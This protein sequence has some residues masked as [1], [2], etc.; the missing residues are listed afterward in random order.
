MDNQ[1]ENQQSL[2]LQRLRQRYRSGVTPEAVMTQVYEQIAAY[3]DP[4]I[5]IYLAPLAD[6]LARAR[7]L[8]QQDLDSLP[9]YGVP[10]AIKDNID[11]AESSTTA[12]C[13]AFAYRP[14]QSAR[15]VQQLCAAGAIPIGKTNLDQFATGLVGTRSPYGICR[16]PFDPRFIPGGSSAGSGVAV[17]AGLVSFALGTDTAGS[18]R[19]PAAFTNIVGLKP[20]K[21]YLSTR[22]LVPAVRS[23]DCISIFAL[24]CADAET[25]LQAAAGFDSADAWSRPAAPLNLPDWAKLRVGVPAVESLKF[26]G[27]AE[28]ERNYRAGLERLQALGGQLVE[29][30][31]S[32]FAETAPL[33][34]Q[35]AWVAER[36]AALGDFLSQNLE[37]MEPTVRQIIAGGSA[38][39]AVAAYEGIYRLA[40]LKRQSELQWQQMDILALPTTGTIYS[41]AAVQAEP[42]TLN[43]NLGYYTNFVNLLDLAAIAVPNGFQLDGLPT[44]L[45]LIAPAGSDQALCQLGASYQAKLQADLGGGLGATSALL[46]PANLPRPGSQPAPPPADW[47]KI[48]VVGAHLSGQPLNPQLTEEQGV[49]LRACQTRPIY[50]LY[51]LVDGAIPKPGL[52]R[53]ADGQGYAIEL[54]VWALPAA[55]FGRFVN[56]IPSPLGIGTV[57]LEDG[58]AVKGFLCEP[59]ALAASPEISQFGGWRAYLASL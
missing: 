15:V 20:T 35:G 18:G 42:L 41:I 9:L 33:L 44:G 2:D 46:P 5:W 28:A 12:G 58:E 21:G 3:N 34:Y 25:V 48:A 23:L 53:Q 24:T 16:N 6:S 4:A 27:N 29:I 56:N 13:P 38:Y 8:Q 57:I 45:T 17:A 55:G 40:E 30:D 49:L 47:I 19:V 22:G 52:V 43:S 36:L 51:A 14:A 39:D 26:F 7:A 32:A 11:W 59:F 54:E 50:K 1:L 37:A 10:F 31:F